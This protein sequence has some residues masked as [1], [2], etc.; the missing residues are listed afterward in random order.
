MRSTIRGWM[1]F[2]NFFLFLTISTQAQ[3]TAPPTRRLITQPI[4]EGKLV[5]LEGNTRPEATAANDR[6]RVAD[7]MP[8]EHMLLQLRRPP[9]LESALD[10]LIGQL[11]DS[12]SESFH[13]WLTA[14]EFG[15]KFG[16]AQEDIAAITQWLQSHGFQINVVYPNK[17]LIDFSGT[18]GQVREAFHT[19]IHF[20]AAHGMMHIAN[21]SD[22][23]IPAALA[24]AV[25]GIVSLHDFRPHPTHVMAHPNFTFPGGGFFGVVPPDL[26]TIYNLNPLF[27]AGYSGQGQTIVV[28]EDSDVYSTSDWSTFRSTFGLSGYTSGSFTEVHP[29]PPSGPNN[30]SDPGV[31]LGVDDEAILDAEYSSAAAPSAAIELASCTTTSTFGGLIALQNL[32][33]ESG[34]PPPIVS[35]SYAECEPSNG[36]PANAAYNAAYQ[37]AVTE[38]V[39]VFVAAGDWGSAVC[40]A[41][42]A[43]AQHGI[44]VNGFAS[45][46]YNVAVG[47]TDFEDSY[48]NQTSTYWSSTNSSTYGSALSYIPEIPWNDSCGS[49]LFSNYFYG[50]IP[51]YGSSGVCNT[52]GLAVFAAGSGGPSGCATGTP[53]INGVVSGTCQGYAKPAW[54][55][56]IGNPS[57][58]VRD[59]PDVSLFASNGAWNHDYIF[60]WSDTAAGGAACTGSP[61]GW[62]QAGGT[63]FASPIMAGI[64]ALINQ[65]TSTRWGN[66]NYLYYRAAVNE[67]GSTGSTSC[68]SSLGNG[69]SS[70]C[71][72]YD[73]TQG[74]MDMPCTGTHNCYLPSGTY[75]VLSTSN[76]SYAI[77]YQSLGGWDF[78]S[79][80]GSVNATN[81]VNFA[82][83]S[84]TS[85][86]TLTYTG[87]LNSARYGHTA[88]L[89]NDGLV[90]IAGGSNSSGYVTSAELYGSGTF[91]TT[92]GGFLST[93]GY[94][95]ATLL[96]SG[97][98]LVAGGDGP[99]GLSVSSAELYNPSTETFSATGSLHTGRD[100]ETATLLNNG[101]VL[102]VG[103]Y[104]F[105]TRSYLSSAELYNPSTG[106]FSVTGSLHTARELHTATL[107]QNGMVLIVGGH[108]STGNIT[109][110]ELYNPS[111]GTFTATGN[112]NT[113]RDFHTATLL[114]SGM[115]LIAAGRNTSGSDVASAELYNPSSGT[116][117]TT[118]SLHTARESHTATLLENGLVLIAGGDDNGTVLSSVELYNTATGAF[119]V[120]TSLNTARRSHTA[121]L[122]Q[123]GIV[124]IVGGFGSSS[125]YL[126]SAELYQ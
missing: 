86:P 2:L 40:D 85:P 73:V 23:R 90:L 5:R 56:L 35:V 7:T 110:S 39:S 72:F 76:S 94:Y 114:Q 65:R 9:E 89:L 92:A 64:Q 37:Q 49:Q 112:L 16:L 88:T 63:S 59:L 95:P 79:G 82:E 84:S 121:T 113:G 93:G 51:P 57:D 103:G 107:L 54:Q 118:G 87:S 41:N 36:A 53:S 24:P 99:S 45:T 29:A 47:G 6:G 10:N 1:F 68:Q 33:N 42:T 100:A 55:F 97:L 75:G 58:G 21:M 106:T 11:H 34:S 119:T 124:L 44:T 77:A 30:C 3:T 111:T 19:E 8:M 102:I 4:D 22:P 98:V 70:S 123:N 62:S 125:Q 25:V 74:D 91:T 48:F 78:A 18:A 50:G 46:P 80:I 104:N 67:Y 83:I 69:A 71:I 52:K 17:T 116:F 105:S 122:L 61:S 126:S 120:T 108:N 115:V 15:K 117:T 13:N 38:G 28:I 101:E 14:D 43:Y 27:S 12:N 109:S 81:L 32:L 66:P 96:N 60:C 20:V 31:V 26:A